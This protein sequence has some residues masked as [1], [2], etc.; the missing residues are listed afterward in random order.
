MAQPAIA[1][2]RPVEKMSSAD[3]MLRQR[4]LSLI[5][6]VPGRLLVRLAG[7]LLALATTATTATSNTVAGQ[8]ERIDCLG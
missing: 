8:K 2:G 6:V 3:V 1:D 4:L 7:Y 5:E